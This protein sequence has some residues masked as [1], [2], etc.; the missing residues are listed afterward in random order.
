MIEP[1]DAYYDRNLPVSLQRLKQGGVRLAG[2]LNQL[3]EE[4]QVSGTGAATGS[5]ALN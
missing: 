2:L 1:G 4:R 5:G 3:V